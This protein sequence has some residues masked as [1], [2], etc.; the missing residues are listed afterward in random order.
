[1]QLVGNFIIEGFLNFH[2]GRSSI[3]QMTK[4]Y[5]VRLDIWIDSVAIIVTYQVIFIQIL[6]IHDYISSQVDD[7][8]R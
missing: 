5:M 6:I 4:C 3:S 7:M 1:M 8:G 2:F